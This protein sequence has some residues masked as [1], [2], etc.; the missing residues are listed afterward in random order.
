M[1]NYTFDLYNIEY[2]LLVLVRI[3]CF[4]FTA[5][6]FSMRGVP[7]ITKIGLSGILSI[8]M[9][10][11]MTPNEADYT[12]VVGYAVLVFREAVTGLL[13]GYSASIANYIVM[14]AG[15]VMDMDIG[16]A[17]VTEFDISSNSQITITANMYYY[18]TLLLLLVGGMHRFLIRA[19]ADSF[20]LIPLGG[21]V[22]RRDV[23]LQSVIVYMRNLFVLGFRIMLPV[24]AVMLIMNVILGIMA[25]VAPQMNMF[26]VG[27][28]IKILAAFAVM[29]LMVFLFPEV[30][31]MIE[32]QMKLN[33]R[34]FAGG[35]HY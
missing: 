33:L 30:V 32:E 10:G 25:K 9:M 16:F 13:L 26:S 23:L 22:F 29:Y 28:Q 21:A 27:V 15:N 18:F 11:T 19:L 20:S 31:D 5:P 12:S 2:F 8:L 35:L 14:F 1:V 3:S 6:F 7:N 24:F 17:M 4:V 34:N